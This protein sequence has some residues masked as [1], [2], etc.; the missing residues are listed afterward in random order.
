MLLE[1]ESRCLMDFL[2]FKYILTAVFTFYFLKPMEGS[3]EGKYPIIIS[4]LYSI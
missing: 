4:I 1:A 3:M 2:L